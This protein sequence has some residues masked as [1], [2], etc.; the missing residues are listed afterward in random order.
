MSQR[1][2]HARHEQ[3]RDLDAPPPRDVLPASGLVD[4]LVDLLLH[5]ATIRV[6]RHETPPQADA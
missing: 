6:T 4:Q 5:E 1:S 3:I 2:L